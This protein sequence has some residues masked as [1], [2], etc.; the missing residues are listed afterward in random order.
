MADPEKP[1]VSTKAAPRGQVV[2]ILGMPIADARVLLYHHI[3][4]WGL[5]NQVVETVVTDATGHFLFKTPLTFRTPHGTDRNDH[6][7]LIASNEN[8]APAWAIIVAGTPEPAGYSL[9]MTKPASQAC[10]VFDMRAKPVEGATVY[11]VHA[12]AQADRAPIFPESL[13]LPGDLGICRGVTDAS[14]R[15]TLTNLPDTRCQLIATKPGS[16]LRYVADTTPDGTQRFTLR[17]EG[18]LEGRVV[19]PQGNPVEGA[20][21]W[22]YPERPWNFHVYFMA[23]T[24]QEGRYRI[25]KIWCEGRTPHSGHY[26][27]GIRHARFTVATREVAFA[28]GQSIAGFDFEAVPGTEIVGRLLNPADEQP[29]AGG[30][31]YIDSKSGRQTALTDM[32][33]EFRC[34]VAPGEVFVFFGS[35]PGGMYAEDDR[36][37]RRDPTT[38]RTNASGDEMRVTLRTGRL[39][40]LGAMQGRVVDAVGNPVRFASVSPALTDKAHTRIHTSGWTGNIFRDIHTNE[41]GIFTAT[42][43][44]GFE[45][46]FAVQNSA[47]VA[48][49]VIS[50]EFL[51]DPLVLSEP[52]VLR[53]LLAAD[54]VLVDLSGA[55]RCNFTVEVTPR[56][57][58]VDYWTSRQEITTDAEGRLRLEHVMP[59]LTYRIAPADAHFDCGVFDPATRPAPVTVLVTDRYILRVVDSG[60]RAISVKKLMDFFVWIGPDDEKSQW[61]NNVP[62]KPEKMGDELLLP[63]ETFL[64]QPGK[65][66]DMRLQTEAG[67]IVQATGYLPGEGSVILRVVCHDDE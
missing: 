43:P 13:H 46:T 10:E 52:V 25:D 11:L 4:H 19:D 60:G 29:V 30:L 41:A 37:L 7:V 63:K 35:P 24:D 42:M 36:G 44:V 53:P 66:I 1:I 51:S 9:C 48:G 47:G 26:R 18:V 21:V 22:I 64:S 57:R 50:S 31:V 34:R 54:F 67:K 59:G 12:I 55:P 38:R 39:G 15:V 5:G 62:D 33:G 16:E 23:K 2:D 28:R 45:V 40:R 56:A 49:A 58:G 61:T 14:G 65:Q 32:E 8:L 20:T 3:N 6:Y 27:A 17:P